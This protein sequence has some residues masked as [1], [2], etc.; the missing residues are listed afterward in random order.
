[1]SK[2]GKGPKN[3]EEIDNVPFHHNK[4]GHDEIDYEPNLLNFENSG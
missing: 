1:L 3:E 4:I 2:K